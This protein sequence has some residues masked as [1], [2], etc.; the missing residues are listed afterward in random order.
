MVSP[1]GW[2]PTLSA[3]KVWCCHDKS[4]NQL[5]FQFPINKAVL[6]P[7]TLW[8]GYVD[9]SNDKVARTIMSAQL[10][11]VYHATHPAMIAYRQ[12]IASLKEFNATV[13]LARPCEQI[14]PLA[15]FNA[16]NKSASAQV[17]CIHVWSWFLFSYM[18]TVPNFFY[19]SIIA[20]L[21]FRPE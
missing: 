7:T 9:E 11:R 4:K 3:G 14:L 12:A 21:S 13:P 19:F 18:S 6:D 16:G 1:S 10:K 2:Y 15:G 5:V 8:K 17:R 20:T